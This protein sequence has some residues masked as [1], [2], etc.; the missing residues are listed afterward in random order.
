VYTRERKRIG[1][2]WSRITCF[3]V[4]LAA[5]SPAHRTLAGS[6]SHQCL[7]I[8]IENKQCKQINKEYIKQYLMSKQTVPKDAT[9]HYELRTREQKN[10]L[11]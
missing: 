5:Q 9:R 3:A 1:S 8:V 4:P 7:M 10:H 2:I 11:N 6:R